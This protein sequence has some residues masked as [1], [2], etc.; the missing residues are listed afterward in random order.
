MF[1]GSCVA[2]ITPMRSNGEIDTDKLLELVEWHIA[3][4]TAAIV[5][6]GTTGESPTLSLAEQQKMLTLVCDMANKRIP[7]IAG[8]GTNS[9][10]TTI[11][12]T[13]MAQQIGADACLIVAPYYNRPTQAGLIAHFT[14]VAEAV[15]MPILLYNVP[16]RTGCDLLPESVAILSQV[17]NIVGIKEATGN[18]QRLEA[19]QANCKSGFIFYS[20]DDPTALAFIRQGGMGVISIT[21][22]VAP[23]L[24]QSMCH[25]ALTQDYDSAEALDKKLHA[26]HRML[27]IEPNPIPVKWAMQAIGKANNILRL[28]LTPLSLEH[29]DKLKNALEV[30]GI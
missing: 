11:E 28:P 6:A 30:A 9:T 25:S 2:L 23:R 16:S 1:Q 10:Q 22:N 15:K 27:I 20:G 14:A 24:M 17:P 5:I 18:L 4:G 26:L 29:Q 7:I 19:L 8:T 3:E 12:R 21:A 13:Q